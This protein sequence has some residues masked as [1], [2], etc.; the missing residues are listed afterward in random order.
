MLNIS[1]ERINQFIEEEGY[2]SLR[3]L[4]SQKTSAFLIRILG[5][6][7]ILVIFSMFLP[8]TQNIRAKGYVTTLSPSSRPQSVQ[9]FI[10]GRIEKWFVMEGQTV[11]VGDTIMVISEVKE[12]YL[13]PEIMDRTQDQILAKKESIK[14]YNEKAKSLREQYDA[15]TRN[16]V[17][18]L[19]QNQIKVQQTQLKI[20]S[21]SLELRATALKVEI[22][23]NQ[24]TRM[25][26]LYSEGLK[27]LT[28]LEAKRL[29]LR[30]AQAKL[31]EIQNKLSAAQNELQ[32]LDANIRAIENEFQ[33][34][35]SKSRSEIMSA[36]SGG[37]DT[38]ASVDK[39]QSQFNTYEQRRNNYV[40]K[41]PISGIVTKAMQ[42]G[43]GEIVKSGDQIISIMP[44][45]Y[46]LAVEMYVNPRDMPLLQRDQKVRVQFDGWPA[47][48]FSGWPNNSYGT[49][50]G[51]IFAIDNLISENGSYRILVAPDADE[52]PWPDGVRVGGGASTI[53]LLNTVKIGYEIWRQLN[54]FPADYYQEIEESMVKQ[55]APLRKVK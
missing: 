54:G 49:F 18:K 15:L 10:G 13:D 31:L 42:T 52:Q 47:I 9:A 14:A 11:A 43:V 2:R 33:D 41:S 27:S 34:K 20:Q 38:Q 55:K 1:P 5:G 23:Q 50:G 17:V 29:S 3:Y 26:E 48:V 36:L 40:I 44:S 45:V 46:D 32:N 7:M 22:A 8:W 30:E 51:R 39:L 25:E 24:L 53:T 35:I 16:L 19:E 4:N 6:L 21:D 12:E 37:Y 28:E